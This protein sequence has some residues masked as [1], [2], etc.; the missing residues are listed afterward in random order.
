[1]AEAEYIFDPEWE[2]ER[3]RMGSGEHLF[4]P[5][6]RQ[7]CETVG[8]DDGWECM[9]LGAGAGSMTSWMCERVGPSGKVL[10]VDIDTR[11]V[12]RLDHPNLEVRQHDIA[13][14]PVGERKFDLIHARLVLEHIPTRDDVLPQLVAAL[15]PGGWLV[16]EDIDST[17]APFV[18]AQKYFEYPVSDS[19]A[20]GQMFKAVDD[21]LRPLGIMDIEY[22]RRLPG[23]LVKSGLEDVD[24][25]A[26]SRLYRGG[27]ERAKFTLL[28][29]SSLREQI[30]AAGVTEEDYEFVVDCLHDPNHYAMSI[31]VVSAWGRKPAS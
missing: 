5:T 8:I 19:H 29:T 6:S 15:K 11:F 31:P 24:A 23:E 14:G 27:T 4:D 22:G 12:E 13:S 20:P 9:E 2:Q 26:Q 3:E 21:V 17:D 16:A 25:V 18:P 28:T 10:A 30:I 7:I 1:M